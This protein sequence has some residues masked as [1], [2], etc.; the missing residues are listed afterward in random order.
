VTDEF[1]PPVIR[2]KDGNEVEFP[3]PKEDPPVELTHTGPDGE[4]PGEPE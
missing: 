4:D 1:E 3:G 2:D